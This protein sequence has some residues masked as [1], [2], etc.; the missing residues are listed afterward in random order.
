MAASS[1]GTRLLPPRRG[2]PP[3]R[4]R[5]ATT[6]SA[7]SPHRPAG[8]ER[9]RPGPDGRPRRRARRSREKIVRGG[10]GT[11][12]RGHRRGAGA[13]PAG[14]GPSRAR[15]GRGRGA[16]AEGANEGW[17]ELWSACARGP[18]RALRP[19][20]TRAPPPSRTDSRGPNTS[21]T[22]RVD[23][24]MGIGATEHLLIAKPERAGRPTTSRSPSS[25]VA[26]AWS[27]RPAREG[28]A[29]VTGA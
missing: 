25:A 3:P 2:G 4:R 28:W 5:S 23:D 21:R 22:I 8:R 26:R 15:R 18:R 24:L 12:A 27:S 19:G 7:R 14:R 20:R 1:Y 6:P 17:G 29:A 16:A 10:G 13:P 9:R 11:G